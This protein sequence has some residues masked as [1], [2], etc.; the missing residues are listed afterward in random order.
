MRVTIAIKIACFLLLAG[1]LPLI[2][3]GYLNYN[4]AV[5]KITVQIEN[6]LSFFTGQERDHID[7]FFDERRKYVESLVYVPDILDVTPKLIETFKNQG[8]KSEKYKTLDNKIRSF[9]T[10]HMETYEY[11]DMF[12][13]SLSGDIVF[14]MARESDFGTNLK[15]GIYNNSEL[16][17]SFHEAEVVLGTVVSDFRYYEPSK[18]PAVFIVSPIYDQKKVSG[19]LAIQ[20]KAQ[21][22]Y[23]L[24]QDFTGLDKTGEI[25]LVSKIDNSAVFL[26]PLRRDPDAAFK[27]KVAMGSDY[28]IPV[29][30]AA[31]GL[32]GSGIFL[33]DRGD[34]V[35]AAWYYFPYLRMGMVM[36]VMTAEAYAPIYA[37]RDRM[38]AVGV[39]T[40]LLLMGAA[41]FLARVFSI[42]INR[43]TKTAERMA[44][45]DLTAK[46]EIAT[47]D[48]IGDLGVAFNT[49]VESLKKHQEKADLIAWRQTGRMELNAMLSGN[50]DLSELSRNIITFLA[51]Y[52]DADIG[53][54]YIKTGEK[55]LQL[56]GSYA[57]S[58]TKQL[59]NEFDVGDGLVGQA[60]LEKK[61]ILLTQIPEGYVSVRSAIGESQPKIIVID[62]FVHDGEVIGVI[63]LATLHSF[64]ER[65][66]AFLDT[67]LEDIALSVHGFMAHSQ[68]RELLKQ[69]QAQAEELQ[70]REE[71]LRD[72]NN[73]LERQTHDLKCSDQILR[74]SQAQLEEN[75]EKL[76]AQ[77]EELRLANEELEKNTADLRASRD[78]V[79]SKNQHLEQAQLALE[80]KAE[81]LAQSSQ[82]KSEFLANMSHELRTPLN[83]LLILAK[84]LS[85]NKQGNLT[86]KQVEFSQTIHDSGNDLLT[87]INNILDLSKIESG[88]VAVHVE[89][90][91]LN[92]FTNRLEK[93]FRPLAENKEISFRIES[94][95]APDQWLS[96]GQKLDQIVKNLLS[97]AIKF[98]QQGE[99]VLRIAPVAPDVQLMSS[100]LTPETALA[101]SVSDSGIGI[102]K[103]KHTAI[104][105][106]FQQADGTTSRKYGGTGLGLSISLELARLL[107]GEIQ[108]ESEPGQGST[109]TLYIPRALAEKM[110][111][112]IDRPQKTEQQRDKLES[113][114]RVKTENAKPEIT[115]QHPSTPHASPSSV[116]PDDRHNLKSGDRSLLIIEDDVRFAAILVDMAR[117]HG[118]KVLVAEDG[119]TGLHFADY[120]QPSGIVLDLGLPSMDGWQVMQ[121]L[122]DGANT[123]HIPVH[124]MSANDSTLDAMKNGAV[125]FLTKPVSMAN[126]EQA[127]GRIE[128][129]I[130][131][132]VKR[133]LLVEDDV[134]QLKSICELIGVGDVELVSATSGAAAQKLLTKEVFDCIVLDL[135]LSDM[136]GA[137]L[138]ETLRSQ[139]SLRQIPVVV[140]TGKELKPKEQAIL[141]RYAQS[142]VIKDAVS[143]ERL[144]DDTALFLHR[145]ES[146]L[147]EDR[148]R[149]IR[150]LHDNELVFAERKVLIA[151]DD[152]RNVFALS[153]ALQ[154]KNMQVLVAK[155][156]VEALAKLERNPDTAIVLMDIMMPEMDGYEAMRKIREQR[157]F[158]ELPIIALTAKAMRGD[159]AQCIEAGASDYLAK[160]L[161]IEKLLSMM[162]VWLH[163]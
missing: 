131:R 56:M 129:V 49:M 8:V 118:F 37:L 19:F 75:N 10:H 135:G 82:Y 133:L 115:P 124:V 96:D 117:E 125:G 89:P 121:S 13:I 114:L 38:L 137:E 1:L 7:T 53:A 16:A 31:L 54:I 157:C 102:S 65:K 59:V 148:R 97:N 141:E 147:P 55:R 156:G 163:R 161:I 136:S 92:D 139:E 50:H 123:R 105:E 44:S 100:E 46:T 152:M 77:Q 109:F 91:Y 154:E 35:M 113:N 94:D 52:L 146:S 140:Y 61:R 76:Q 32:Q 23:D 15:N 83:S 29:Q 62:P 4:D 6:N 57:F 130:D 93:S 158:S 25:V 106:A 73:L 5:E 122:K 40:F 85:D 60:A 149:M 22:I 14:S 142:I 101:I 98:T 160:P 119:E 12:I 95:N 2:I 86:K 45:G 27:R 47:R 138:L 30:Q 67:V 69:T 48:E 88:N 17:N 33:N 51:G 90:V 63:E 26:N 127:F 108:I 20:I 112:E 74:D 68:V 42:P 103:E 80:Q 58:I 99:V 150:M 143:P 153:A 41:W 64:S 111:D 110:P 72:S 126:M 18:E 87:L 79:E 78:M 104:F 9:L 71:E 34:E 81:A 155:N 132:P 128:A 11:H 39:I 134:A 84:L 24:V 43:L 116:V 162:R 3:V 107:G 21:V 159:R 151:D 120:Y 70:A 66:L 28:G 36:E 145:V 144:L